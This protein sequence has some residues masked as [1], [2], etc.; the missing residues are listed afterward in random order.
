MNFDLKPT[1][2]YVSIFFSTSII[3]K[4]NTAITSNYIQSLIKMAAE[5]ASIKI[6]QTESCPLVVGR[7]F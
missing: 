6:I 5:C 2:Y 7:V 1:A 4:T 3:E